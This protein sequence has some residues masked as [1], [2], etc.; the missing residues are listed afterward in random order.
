V[1][2]CEYRNQ[3]TE[4]EY[5]RL[6]TAPNRTEIKKSKPTQPYINSLPIFVGIIQY[7]SL[8]SSITPQHPCLVVGSDNL[9]P[10]PHSGFSLVY[11]EVLQPSLCKPVIFTQSFFTFL[12]TRPYHLSLFCWTTV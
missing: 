12:A 9:F 7:L 2:V 10:Q 3:K 5:L 8:I 11:L 6:K 4:T 1:V